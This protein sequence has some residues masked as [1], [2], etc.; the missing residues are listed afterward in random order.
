MGTF[1]KATSAEDTEQ[2]E[3]E[4]EEAAASEG[5]EKN[6]LEWEL[7]AQEEPNPKVRT[8]T[9][10]WPMVNKSTASV[11]EGVQEFELRLKR[12]GIIVRSSQ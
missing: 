5:P 1:T 6:P 10:A 7:P 4:V 3:K 11:S 2:V 9:L 12:R 8:L